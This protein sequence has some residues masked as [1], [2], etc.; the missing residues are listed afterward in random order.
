[1]IKDI[2]RLLVFSVCAL[3]LPLCVKAEN[4][5]YLRFSCTKTELAPGETTTCSIGLDVT[6]TEITVDGFEGHVRVYENDGTTQT[7]K[8]LL[9]NFTFDS[10]VWTEPYN[11]ASDGDYILQLATGDSAR[12]GNISVG[13]FELTAGSDTGSVRVYLKDV[14]FGTSSDEKDVDSIFVQIN[15]VSASG[16]N[17]NTGTNTG[18][19]DNTNTGTNTETNT[20]ISDNTD[21]EINTGVN[22]DNDSDNNTSSITSKK[23]SKKPV[24]P[25]TG[26]TVSLV[27]FILQRYTLIG[28]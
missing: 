8:L 3:V 28:K 19:D 14:V 15:V 2:K 1:M 12:T 22:T 27:G 11:S 20:G 25:D 7:Q 17:T 24:N 21:T 13:S 18:T 4:E 5:E 10:S 16:D 6:G 26:V 23:E 9:G